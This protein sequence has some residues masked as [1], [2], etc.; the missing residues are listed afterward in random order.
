MPVRE[1]QTLRVWFY[2]PREDPQGL[3]NKVVARLDGPFCHCE[4]Q[5]PDTVA[6][7]VYMGTQV[8][9]KARAFDPARYTCVRVFCSRSDMLLARQCAESSTTQSFS[10]MQML[11]ALAPGTWPAASDAGGTFCSKLVGKVL[12]AAHA[13][14]ANT[15]VQRVTPSGLHRILH[16]RY[17]KGR[18]AAI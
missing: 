13:L 7:S 3:V 2:D 18:V 6:F 4:V 5:F 10:M 8:V 15:D 12:Q 11:L 9:S 17:V 16:E 14:P 1:T